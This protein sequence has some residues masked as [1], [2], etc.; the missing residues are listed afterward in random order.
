MHSALILRIS[1]RF[2][3]QSGTDSVSCW[4]HCSKAHFR[5]SLLSS[6][7]CLIRWSVCSMFSLTFSPEIG[8][9]RGSRQKVFSLESGR[10][11]ARFSLLPLRL[12]GIRWMFSLDSSV[13]AG[14]LSGAASSSS[15]CRFGV[16]SADFSRIRLRPFIRWQ[17]LC[18]RGFPDSSLR[19]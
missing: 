18:L 12:C 14:S 6:A 15:L 9:E 3:N 10:A 19:F 1:L 4:P 8:V 2:C 7:S 16:E 13:Q 11:S 5:I 17:S